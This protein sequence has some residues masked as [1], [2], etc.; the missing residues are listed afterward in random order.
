MLAAIVAG[1]SS[2]QT[3]HESSEYHVV[4]LNGGAAISMRGISVVN[5]RIAWASGTRG[6]VL[7]TTDG[8]ASWTAH[9]VPSGDS[10]DFRDV[11]AFDSLTAY[12]LAAGEDGRIYK[13]V[14]GGR[15]W[16]LQFQNKTKGAFFDCFDF[17]DAQH[18]IAMSDP[19]DGKLLLLRT[20]DGRTWKQV[21]TGAMPAVHNGEAAFAASG[22]CVITAQSSRVYLA[23]GGGGLGR[24]FVSNDRGKT[25][26]VDA[27]PVKAA[28]SSAGIF[29]LAFSDPHH[30]IAIG[31]DYQKPAVEA[32]LAVTSNG[33]KS[34]AVGGKTSYVS[35]AAFVTNSNTV[36][37]VGTPG[38]RVSHDR[39]VTWMTID[40]V[41]YNAVAF[42]VDG[43]GFAVGPK[44]RIARITR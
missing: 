16:Q 34:W 8:G 20:D 25:W 3:S 44:G 9:A 39:G 4:P 21:D 33:G 27:T 12:A 29:S 14:N 23:T 35:G 41:E 1:C 37:A 24:V 31:G 10:L 38:T 43:T 36:V 18:G 5:A 13:T 22:T 11:A 32:E 15:D 19:V 30:G 26:A 7:R 40:S 2:L 6:T 42:A 17:W 28:S